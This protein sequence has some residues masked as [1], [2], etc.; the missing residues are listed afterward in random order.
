M[1]RW[2]PESDVP[3]ELIPA[4]DQAIDPCGVLLWSGDRPEFV[5]DNAVVVQTG[6]MRAAVMVYPGAAG[7]RSSWELLSRYAVSEFLAMTERV[8]LASQLGERFSDRPEPIESVT[9][10]GAAFFAALADCGIEPW[11]FTLVI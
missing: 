9:D 11:R 8:W 3:D 2:I 6:E 5:P 10:D 7:R 1:L 4:M